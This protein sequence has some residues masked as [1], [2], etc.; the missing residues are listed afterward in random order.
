MREKVKKIRAWISIR[1]A[2][3]ATI[4]VTIGTIFVFLNGYYQSGK[5]DMEARLIYQTGLLNSAE[6][7]FAANDTELQLQQEIAVWCRNVP[8]TTIIEKGSCGSNRVLLEDAA[9]QHDPLE[10]DEIQSYDAASST[11]A[12]YN[13]EVPIYEVGAAITGGLALALLVLSVVV[14]LIF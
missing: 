12:D 7:A 8:Q 3:I 1:K 5:S 11:L 2:I 10:G 4:F 9:L 13:H 6:S 14:S